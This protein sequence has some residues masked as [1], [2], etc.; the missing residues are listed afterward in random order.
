M[1]AFWGE[2]ALSFQVMSPI[3]QPRHAILT[4]LY[5]DAVLLGPLYWGTPAVLYDPFPRQEERILALFW[6]E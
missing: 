3:P 6:T 2:A 5:L 1:T 4:A